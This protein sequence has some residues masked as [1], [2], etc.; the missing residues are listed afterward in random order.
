M[1]TITHTRLETDNVFATSLA[2][3]RTI[4][5]PG[6]LQHLQAVLANV[7]SEANKLR[8][9]LPIGLGI[10]SPY[11][12]TASTLRDHPAGRLR[13]KV[14]ITTSDTQVKVSIEETPKT[15]SRIL[16]TKYKHKGEAC[17]AKESHLKDK[18][19]VGCM[20]RSLT[21][22]TKGPARG[23]D[24]FRQKIKVLT[25]ERAYGPKGEDREDPKA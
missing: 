18:S 22:H 3:Q 21:V 7:V 17:W 13:S 9:T 11:D 8:L 14:H 10:P 2:R 25:Q 5:N 4:V 19:I 20:E 23:V 16:E 1:F 6:T 24:L 15:I 12:L